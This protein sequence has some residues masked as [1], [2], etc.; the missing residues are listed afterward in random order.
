MTTSN[1]QSSIELTDAELAML[2]HSA[3]HYVDN[4][5]RYVQEMSP[6]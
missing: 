5:K 4:W 6:L 2:A 1:L 3:E